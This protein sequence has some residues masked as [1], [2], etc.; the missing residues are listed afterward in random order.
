MQ[1]RCVG[2]FVCVCVIQA[3]VLFCRG[4]GGEAIIWQVSGG[5]PEY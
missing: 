4:V 3:A 1:L 5:T 2:V